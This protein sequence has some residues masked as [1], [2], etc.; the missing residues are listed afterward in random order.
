MN[1][2]E[3]YKNPALNQSSLK[4][5]EIDPKKF[6]EEQEQKL[7]FEEKQHFIIGNAVDCLLTR[8]ESFNDEFYISELKNKPSDTVKSI[9]K[10]TF[11][12]VSS[13]IKEEIIEVNFYKYS[14]FVLEAC[15]NH[16]YQKTWKDETRVNKILENWEYWEEI[17]KSKDKTILT[18]EDYKLIQHI[19]FNFENSD[20][21]KDIFSTKTEEGKIEV[22]KQFAI[23]FNFADVDC[24]ALLDILIINH[25]KKEVYIYDIKTTSD[26]LSN[27]PKIAERN[28]YDIQCAFY[29]EAVNKYLIQK[30]LFDYEIK[31]FSFLV[32]S[33]VDPIQPVIF[34]ATP[35]FRIRGL[36]GQHDTYKNRKGIIELIS[37]YKFYLENGFKL[38]RE[39]VENNY[40]LE[41]K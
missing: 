34:K 38:N 29:Y 39:I 40:I 9:I 13:N 3:Y 25:D 11:D 7:F 15:N 41:L 10:E 36:W 32:E 17:V 2:E 21:T 26:L 28:R 24:K 1:I 22:F 14:S 35:E 4:L 33:S 6:F 23:F 20:V 18:V 8:P 37:D 16:N 31:G 30:D 19:V 27:F 12:L 5:L